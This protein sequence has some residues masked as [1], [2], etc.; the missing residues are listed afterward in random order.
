MPVS[1]CETTTSGQIPGP[2]GTC[3]EPSGHRNQR[4][5]GD[6]LH[7]R[8]DPVSQKFIPKFCLESISLPEVLSQTCRMDKP[9]SERVRPANTRDNQ[10]ARG[11][12]KN[13]SNRN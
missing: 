2:R 10:M 5:A 13:I 6:S 4:T 9:Q 1:T 11:K 3:P 12:G 8:V 7:P